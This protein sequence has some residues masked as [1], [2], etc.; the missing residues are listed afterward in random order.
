MEGTF[1][2]KDLSISYSHSFVSAE[3]NGAYLNDDENQSLFMARYRYKNFSF[4]SGLYWAG[5]PS[6]YHSETLDRSLVNYVSDTKIWDNKTM[7]VF[8]FSW[9]FHKGK[10][11][12]VNRKLQNKD[13]DAGTF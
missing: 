9:N 4:S 1:N 13:T 2:W 7:F 10:S 11:Y 5:Q 3:L 8:G 6:K 12:D